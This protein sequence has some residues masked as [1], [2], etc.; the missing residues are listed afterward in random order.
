MPELLT[1]TTANSTNPSEYESVPKLLPSV[2]ENVTLS[3]FHLTELTFNNNSASAV[4]VSVFDRQDV[5]VSVL[6]GFTIQPNQP[7]GFVWK[8][9]LVPGG[10]SWVASVAGVISATARG[11]R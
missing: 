6:N 8:G 7:A 10:F 5:P 1:R 9:R 4:T 2:S 11:Y 3:D